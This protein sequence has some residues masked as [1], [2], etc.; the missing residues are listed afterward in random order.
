MKPLIAL[1]ILF[2]LFFDFYASG[3]SDIFWLILSGTIG[4]IN[5]IRARN[6]VIGDEEDSW[7][8]GQILPVFLLVG[9]VLMTLQTFS[10]KEDQEIPLPRPQSVPFDV[11]GS[12][13]TETNAFG[14]QQEHTQ[15][16]S[17]LMT[18]E[19]LNH[20]LLKDYYVVTKWMKFAVSLVV[21]IHF[22]VLGQ[23][24]FLIVGSFPVNT[25]AAQLAVTILSVPALCYFLI[26]VGL[27]VENRNYETTAMI[28]CLLCFLGSLTLPFLLIYFNN[29]DFSG[30][31][32]DILFFWASVVQFPGTLAYLFIYIYIS[33][34]CVL[35]VQA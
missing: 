30:N 33:A 13:Q 17:A 9:P 2:R 14:E 26:L 24:V 27:R 32:P 34:P 16:F 21:F 22:T 20:I 23:I 31:K 19:H 10:N 25:M 4:T 5:L 28:T 29:T 12:R 15:L 7:T 35:F 11:S 18:R 8:F 1:Y 3:I 6:P